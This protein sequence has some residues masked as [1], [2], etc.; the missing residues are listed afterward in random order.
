MLEWFDETK[1]FGV[2]NTP[3]NKEVFLHISNWEDSKKLNSKNEL[4]ILFRIGFQRNK[5][6]AIS[7]RYFN[8]NE[9]SHWDRVFSLKEYSYS[10]KIKYSKINLLDLVISQ[11][12]QEFDYFKIKKFID[13]ILESYSSSDFFNKSEIVFSLYRSSKNELFR[14]FIL[15][16]VSYWIGKLDDFEIVKFWKEK[17]IIDFT[18]EK[19][20]LTKY[21][22]EISVEDLKR[23]DEIEIRHL[24]VIKKI[25][26]LFQNFDKTE[27]KSF[28]LLIDL[29]E[30]EELRKKLSNDLIELAESY[31]KE[32]YRNEADTLVR[33]TDVSFKELN[34]YLNNQPNFLERSYC[35]SIRNELEEKVYEHGSFRLIVECWKEGMLSQLDDSVLELIPNQ[36]K[37][38]LLNFLRYEKVTNEQ[39]IVVLDELLKRGLYKLVLEES[40]KI[41]SVLFDKYDELVK[42]LA[43][44]QD[45]FELWESKIGRI[46]P[47]DFLTDY[48]SYKEEEYLQLERW[49]SAGIIS[50]DT[51][52]QVLLTI[53]TK[54]L[55]VEDRYDFYK[56]YYSI[57]YL[58]KIE[59]SS[60]EAL[61]DLANPFVTLILWHFNK[62]GS[63]DFETLKGKFIYFSPVDQVFIFK[64]LFYLKHKNEIDFDLNKLD[65][66]IRADIDLYLTNE[67]FN[68]DFVLDVSTHVIIECLK[69]YKEKGDFIFES[70]LILKDLRRNSSK[71][72][73]IGEYF[74]QCLGRM[75]P[76]WNWKTEGKISQV[77]FGNDKFYYAIEFPPGIEVEAQNYYGSYTY[78]EKNP[79]FEHLKEEVKKLPGRKW[80]PEANHWGVPSKYENEVFSFASRN[81]FFIELKDRKHYDNNAHLVDFT[82]YKPD[83]KKVSSEKN[84]PNGIIFCEGRKSKKN[85]KQLNKEFW[86]CCNQECFQNSVVDH[87]SD[88]FEESKINI[89]N[90][91]EY[92]YFSSERQNETKE[93]WEYYT[94]LDFL[95][96]LNINVD[97]HNG[98]DFIKD[99]HYYKYLGHINAFNRL[100]EK[101]YCEEC[102]NLLYPKNTSHFALYRDVRFYCIEDNCSKKGEEI[103]LNHCLYGECKTVIDSRVSKR[104]R[105]GMFICHNCGTC[106]SEEFFKRRLDKLNLVGGYIHPDLIENVNRQNGHLEKKEYYC[107]KCTEMMTEIDD[108]HYRCKNCDVDYNLE[109][110]KWIT[111]KWTQ[112]HRRRKDYPVIT[113]K[114]GNSDYDDLGF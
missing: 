99:G 110:F 114:N 32:Y 100:L 71:R 60:V 57:K 38:D 111:R 66:I 86:W 9:Y 36:S 12:N 1:G 7:C 16:R 63:F 107:F 95:H 48:F 105:H 89:E 55:E 10:V 82:R 35:D 74:D 75:T 6:T 81:R 30:S 59:S 29:I 3:D 33:N 34:E 19:E 17:I 109:K 65:E 96:I 106:C 102:N 13:G 104:C 31:Y 77:F 72:F 21:F 113:P 11:L 50:E 91:T 23:L 90:R 80:N 49:L 68:D 98:L 94:L 4:P 67:R 14:K 8:P 97:E 22:K 41:S 88:N 56:V 101:L 45:Y 15:N 53:I 87:L 62:S 42:S 39:A 58:I 92:S 78:F 28:D 112:I 43:T 85:H 24:I 44:N 51:A 108:M 61:E 37:D 83:G 25:R 46:P 76:N 47:F 2:L 73:K 5:T 79:N 54:N 52:R 84:I 93:I 26:N 64:R 18:P 70:D 20:I 27:F 69:S 40:K 103:Y